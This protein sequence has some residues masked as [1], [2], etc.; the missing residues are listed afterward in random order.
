MNSIKGY[1]SSLNEITRVRKSI[2]NDQITINFNNLDEKTAGELRSSISTCL[3]KRQ[4]EVSSII[5]KP[6]C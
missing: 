1:E 4:S 2:S 5:M 6:N 3:T